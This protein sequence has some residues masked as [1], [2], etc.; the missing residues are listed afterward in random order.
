MVR[1]WAW[2]AVLGATV[3]LAGCVQNAREGRIA[4]S[5][6]AHTGCPLNKIKVVHE[7]GGVVVHGC[8]KSARYDCYAEG[9][10]PAMA[11]EAPEV[12]PPSAKPRRVTQLQV[13]ILLEGGD[14]L[15]L[16][17]TP[18]E[19]EQAQMSLDT[20]THRGCQLDL[21]VDGQLL[22][23]SEGSVQSSRVLPRDVVLDLASARQ[24]GVR[25]CDQ[26]WSLG[27][28]DIVE[29]RHFARR[30]AEELA[31]QGTPRSK[32]SGGK[33]PPLG[34]WQ[35][36]HALDAFPTAAPADAALGGTQ[37]FEKLAP[38]VWRVESKLESGVSQ[39][40]AVAVSKTRLV[41]NCH[42]VEGALRI[43]VQQG[44]TELVAKLHDSDPA[45]DR[46]VLE[47]ADAQLSPVAGVRPY[48]DLKVGEPLYTLGAPSGLDLTLANGILSALREDEGVRYVQT[49]A[50]ISPGSSGGGLFDARGN[51]VGITTL[52]FVGKEHLNQSLNFAIA[53][54]MYWSQ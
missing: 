35:A 5:F 1:G 42:V 37:L 36:W 22:E 20:Y 48:V 34:G 28:D 25:A 23:L 41:T 6:S 54:E 13:T 33:R 15:F 26:R 9:C 17:A 18:Q 43:V 32:S 52:V 31:W 53:A 45:K 38:S 49:T 19:S 50:P 44:K 8:G 30:Y 47:V 39:G 3:L 51:L 21:M 46:C 27:H 11:F 14:G 40:S 2:R 24:V 29:L 4:G 16:T 10:Q 12:P 7:P